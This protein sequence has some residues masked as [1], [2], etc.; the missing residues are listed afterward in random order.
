M[1]KTKRE[2]IVTITETDKKIDLKKIAIEIA[3]QIKEKGLER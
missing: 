1:K 2:V 3:K